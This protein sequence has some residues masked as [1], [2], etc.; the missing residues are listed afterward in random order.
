MSV[1]RLHPSMDFGSVT[2]RSGIYQNQDIPVQVPLVNPLTSASQTL[3]LQVPPIVHNMSKSSLTLNY[4]IP[5]TSAVGL[6]F[7]TYEDLL[8]MEAFSSL[9]FG[10][11]QGTYLC[12]LTNPALYA[13]IIP[14][15]DVGLKQFM[16]N[17]DATGFHLTNTAVAN[18]NVVPVGYVVPANNSYNL[19]AGTNWSAASY[20][21]PNYVRTSGLVAV[22]GSIIV[23]RTIPLGQLTGTL[24]ALKHD[25]FF[26]TVM[27]LT[28]T[29]APAANFCYTSTSAAT[30][31]AAAAGAAANIYAPSLFSVT[32][33]LATQQDPK[34]VDD[35]KSWARSGGMRYQ[36]PFLTTMS[37]PAPVGN[38]TVNVSLNSAYGQKLKRIVSVAQGVA[39][40]TSATGFCPTDISNYNGS[41]ITYIGTTLAGTQL[42]KKS[43][44]NCLL[45]LTTAVGNVLDDYRE[46]KR[47][48][49]D[50]CLQ[51]Y[52]AYSYNWFWCDSFSEKSTT[53][54]LQNDQI[55]EGIQLGLGNSTYAMNMN[56]AVALNI[57]SFVETIRHVEIGS[58][59]PVIV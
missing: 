20:P 13:K 40:Q 4:T 18:A 15:L 22:A 6:Y 16:D 51:D 32:L 34:I 37:T 48:T 57:W 10:P 19:A 9:T 21:Q 11:A 2:Q 47:F 54:A 45:P 33:N 46:M 56:A 52:Q 7:N 55:D 31:T 14:K 8:G 26:N 35:V 23:S 29:T 12:Q 49:I 5:N 36:I 24:F 38:N 41:K 58:A 27:N 43:Q 3:L 59:G 53:P 28:L 25:Q 30:G 44:N 17:D 1:G 39:A 42:Q 50:T